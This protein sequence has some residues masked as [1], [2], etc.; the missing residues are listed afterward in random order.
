MDATI[1]E[2]GLHNSRGSHL[3]YVEATWIFK[4]IMC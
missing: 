1:L 3:N 4:E 2:M